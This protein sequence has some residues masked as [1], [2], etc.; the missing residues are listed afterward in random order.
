MPNSLLSA[1]GIRFILTSMARDFSN[2][3]PVAIIL[4]V[5]VGVGLAEQAGLMTA[6]IKKIV[7]VTPR[8]AVAKLARR[9]AAN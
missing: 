7:E 8:E 5:M 1:D 2:F 9:R 3:G 6:L 4:V